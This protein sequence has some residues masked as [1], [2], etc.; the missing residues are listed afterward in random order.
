M[1]YTPFIAWAAIATAFIALIA[2]FSEMNRGRVSLGVDSILRLHSHFHSADFRETRKKAADLL[3]SKPSTETV[4]MMNIYNVLNF[5]EAV[6]ILKQR[7]VI[8]DDLVRNFFF[9]W[10]HRWYYCAKDDIER[11]RNIH[12][13]WW[14]NFFVMYEKLCSKEDVPPS[15]KELEWFL[16]SESKL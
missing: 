2:F 1:D 14:E 15:E 5:F 4:E 3:R 12:P 16:N 7:K 11:W 6:A 10:M 13:K 9:Y 8:D